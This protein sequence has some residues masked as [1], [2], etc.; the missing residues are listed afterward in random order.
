MCNNIIQPQIISP[1][2]S[3]HFNYPPVSLSLS[4]LFPLRYAGFVVTARDRRDH[5][6]DVHRR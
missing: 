3:E 4:V 6:S 1:G 2:R 5:E